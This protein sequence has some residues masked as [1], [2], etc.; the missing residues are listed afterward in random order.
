MQNKKTNNMKHYILTL[1]LVSSLWGLAQNSSGNPENSILL[2]SGKY[3]NKIKIRN[4]D[5]LKIE[6]IKNGN[7]VDVRIT[8]VEEIETDSGTVWFS[9]TGQAITERQA[10]IYTAPVPLKEIKTVVIP[11]GNDS[12]GQEIPIQTQEQNQ[13]S[14]NYVTEGSNDVEDANYYHRSYEMGVEAA[15][16]KDHSGWGIGTFLLGWMYGAPYLTSLA[17]GKN[18]DAIDLPPGVDQKLYW[19]GYKQQQIIE[20]SRASA[21]GATVAKLT[22]TAFFF[23][24]IF[25]SF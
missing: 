25:S 13:S 6:Y 5:T 19:E 3:I 24:V 14:A 9:E 18:V 15:K 22:S 8:E 4:F 12:A 21:T 7:L 11:A 1:L 23:I 2:K 10:K 16:R 17:T 20:R